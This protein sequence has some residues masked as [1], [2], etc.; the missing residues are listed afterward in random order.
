MVE[1]LTFSLYDSL[2]LF[3][4]E[5]ES[6]LEIAKYD[7]VTPIAIAKGSIVAVLNFNGEAIPVF[8]PVV[9]LKLG[10]KSRVTDRTSLLIIRGKDSRFALLVDEVKAIERDV[11]NIEVINIDE[12]SI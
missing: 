11:E 1:Y 6:V 10:G 5:L 7:R 2:T 3:G 4:V 12:F 8:D 9:Q